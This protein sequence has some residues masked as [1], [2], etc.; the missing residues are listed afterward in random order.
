M[1][2]A[3]T[4]LLSE[5][6]GGNSTT[7]ASMAAIL[8]T[9][10]L[11]L[12]AA[13]EAESGEEAAQGEYDVALEN[14]LAA[15][16][17]VTED[18]SDA[19]DDYETA[20]D[21][22]MAANKA[23]ATDDEDEDVAAAI[24]AHVAASKADATDEEEDDYDAAVAAHVAANKAPDAAAVA[25]AETALYETALPAYLTAVEGDD[26]EAVAAAEATLTDSINAMVQSHADDA[27]PA[28]YEENVGAQSPEFQA[29]VNMMR[30]KLRTITVI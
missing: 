22:W 5:S 23:D 26:A 3:Y 29:G 27:L 20:R 30:E 1:D 19:L 17:N 7:V 9:K 6:H 21:A 10:L 4:T 28:G 13:H 18:Y 2:A 14:L 11:A 12:I 24:T 25:L 8:D 15:V 16:N